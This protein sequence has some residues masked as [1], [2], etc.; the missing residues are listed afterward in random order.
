MKNNPVQG[1]DE[2]QQISLRV[3][4]YDDIFSDFDV[5]GYD[6]RALSGDFLNEIKRAA[7]DKYDNGI[8][9][10]LHVPQSLRDES[11]E[12]VIVERLTGHFNKHYLRLRKEKR[13]IIRFGA[14]MVLLGVI[15]MLVATRILYDN[16][17]AENM[18]LSFLRTFFEPLSIF[19]LWE[20]LDQILFSTKNV[21][22]E[23]DFYRKMSHEDGR[24]LFR[25]GEF[26]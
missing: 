21:Q 25:S 2:S 6:R 13:K 8:E 24:I 18:S 19:L 14:G 15:S 1:A 11:K 4:Q 26:T 16:P 3:A 17:T 20:G 22:P 12:P 5:R 7:N 10:I 23:L 9:L